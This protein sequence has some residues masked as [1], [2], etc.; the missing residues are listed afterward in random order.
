MNRIEKPFN[1]RPVNSLPNRLCAHAQGQYT[2]NH[3]TDKVLRRL[4][5]HV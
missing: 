2:R 4:P 3:L 1:Q 5:L